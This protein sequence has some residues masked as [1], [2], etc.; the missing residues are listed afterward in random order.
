MKVLYR[1]TY[2]N[3]YTI[4]VAYLLVADQAIF[5]QAQ[6]FKAGTLV[7]NEIC[8]VVG[9]L[10]EIKDLK[11]YVTFT[12]SGLWFKDITRPATSTYDI[13]RVKQTGEEV[14]FKLDPTIYTI[15]EALL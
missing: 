8:Q 14:T 5:R 4:R 3:Y 10:S 9:N 2:K 6:Y 7:K 15:L 12:P 11:K 1:H 13:A